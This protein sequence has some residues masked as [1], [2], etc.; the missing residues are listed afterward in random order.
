MRI[1]TI[2]FDN[3]NSLGGHFEI[4]L[5]HPALAEGGIFIISGPTGSGKTT[6][7]DAITYALYGQTVRQGRLTAANNEIMTHGA[8]HCRAEAVVEK[9]GTRYLFSTEQRRK[10]TRSEKADPYTTAERR[11]YRLEADG[12]ATLL[13]ADVGGVRQVAEGLMKYEN[14]CRC[15]MLAQGDFARFL[16][17]EAAERSEALATITGTGIYQRIGEKVQEQVAAL[18]AT[19][20]AVSLLPTKDAA[21]R[22]EAE[23][24][25]SAQEAACRRQQETLDTLTHALA[26][27]EALA[28]AGAARA[29]SANTLAQA[30]AALQSF[31]GAGKPARL[32]AAEAALALR[33]QDISRNTAAKALAD[34]Q[35]TLQ[36]EQE[37]LTAHPGTE[38]TEAAEQT[39]AALAAEQPELE[40]RLQYLADT[41]QP[42]ENAIGKATIRAQAA[43][44][45]AAARRQEAADAAT[46]AQQAAAAAERREQA[47]QAARQALA[48]LPPTQEAERACEAA[49]ERAELAY[50]IQSVSSK[51]EELYRDFCKGKLPCCPCCGSPQPHK[52]PR[53]DESEL[54]RAAEDARRLGQELRKLQRQAEDA[55]AALAAA[56]AAHSAAQQAAGQA[57]Q[58]AGNKARLHESAR[59]AAAEAQQELEQL[60]SRLAKAW[61]GGNAREAEKTARTR[62]SKLQT[63]CTRSKDAL[64]AYLTQR[65]SHASLAR[66]AADRLPQQECALQQATDS[67]CRALRE[68]GFADEKE[69][70]AALLPTAELEP[71]RQQHHQL[72][73]ALAAAEGAHR[74]ACAQEQE[75]RQQQP[76]GNES[77]DELTRKKRA[78]EALLHEQKELLTAILAE[79]RQDDD[80]HRAN[81]EKEEQLA[82]TRAELA[83]WQRLYEILG[84]SK[85]GFKKYAQKLTFNLLLQEANQRLRQLNERYSLVQDREKELGLRVIDRYQDDEKG[86]ACSNLS[87]GESFIV[88]LA[89]ALGL[90]RMA[91]ET[92]IDTLFLDEGFGT[93]DAD[94]LEQ[95]LHCLQELRTDGKLIGI[96]SHV[97]ALKERIPARIELELRGTA[98]LSTIAAHEAVVAEAWG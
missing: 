73:H 65:E 5:T 96:I 68:Q 14:F 53:Q 61:Q 49:Q 22:A 11:A 17:A 60:Q 72:R 28:R 26:R 66:A 55:K 98:G 19:L 39:A 8:R 50:K 58:E 47:L 45:T 3:I 32:R 35:S 64:Q 70:S 52:H 67:F 88:S 4:D 9:D 82:G 69:Y 13:S 44:A 97:E 79:L 74:Q 76:P 24:R 94:A 27:Q 7:L 33:P 89:L 81:A 71:L 56:T 84:N 46:A 48:A 62:L 40:A 90:S 36:R 54:A 59:S 86:R 25:R 63:A 91:G 31:C 18:K 41:V 95:V 16:K 6:L 78:T 29:A 75:L 2:S 85:D 1:E 43:A 12:S 15:M 10:K 21:A 92:R 42:L 83:Q 20:A 38:L 80:A 87:G 57:K 37:W 93:L 30:Q 23:Q 34:T 77:A 51:L